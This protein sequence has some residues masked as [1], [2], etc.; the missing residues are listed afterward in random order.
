MIMGQTLG[1]G[2]WYND[3]Q[4]GSDDSELNGINKGL[5]MYGKINLP[6]KY[7][8]FFGLNFGF[9]YMKMQDEY[10]SMFGDGGTIWANAGITKSISNKRLHI[11]C[12]VDNIFNSGGFSMER[13]KPLIAGIDYIQP[14]YTAGEEYTN[15][16]SSRNG[17]TFSITIKYNFGELQRNKQKF[18][19]NDS[20]RGGMDRF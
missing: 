14:P 17:R 12:N 19:F 15:L 13:I 20:E 5:N 7:I 9:Y 16:S 11:S 18:K 2:F 3:V 8:Q 1:G 4:D 6:E 10:G